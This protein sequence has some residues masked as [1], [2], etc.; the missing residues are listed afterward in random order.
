MIG[1]EVGPRFP[2]G[3]R[4]RAEED[5]ARKAQ[6][7]EATGLGCLQRGRGEGGELVE[8]IGGGGKEVANW[9]AAWTAGVSDGWNDARF[10]AKEGGELSVW[11]TVHGGL[12]LCDREAQR[13]LPWCRVKGRRT[14]G[15]ASSRGPLRMTRGRQAR[16]ERGVE[17]AIEYSVQR[18]TSRRVF[19]YS[20]V[21]KQQQQ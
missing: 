14:D 6:G 7:R 8:F 15:R 10:W 21:G 11:S 17:I 2:V 18:N 4:R 1:R 16:P 3:C 20:A 19:C 5:R 13:S 9:D 12:R